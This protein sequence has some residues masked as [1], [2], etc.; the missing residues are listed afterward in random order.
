MRT[1]GV[2][3]VV[4]CFEGKLTCAWCRCFFSL[5]CRSAAALHKG[6]AIGV[7]AFC[8]GGALHMDTGPF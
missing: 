2:F 1:S 7:N 6:G 5:V 4:A 8:Q 3:A